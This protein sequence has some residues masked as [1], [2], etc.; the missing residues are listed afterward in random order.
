VNALSVRVFNTLYFHR[1]AA[2]TPQRLWHYRPFLYPLDSILDWNRMYGPRGFF[3]Y[4]CV[5]PNAP[6]RDALQDMLNRISRS[7]QGSFLV[8]LKQFGTLPSIGMLSFPRAGVTLALD[9][10]NRGAPTLQLLES[11]DAITRA[12]GGAVYPAK[13]ARMS[14]ESFQQYF[15]AWQQFKRYI[16]PKFSSSFWRRVSG[17]TT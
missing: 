1:P 15:P 13:D 12:A 9:F 6:A 10:P 5:L 11:L 2:Q 3:Q 17:C 7:G 16:D 8:V 4:Q 14:A